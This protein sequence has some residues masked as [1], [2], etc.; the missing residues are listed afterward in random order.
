VNFA[1]AWLEEVREIADGLDHGAIDELAAQILAVR[2]RRG[3]I[4]VLGLGGSAANAQHCVNDLRVRAG[5]AAFS[6][7]DNVAELTAR[8][9]DYG[10]KNTLWGMLKASDLR[11]PD[12]VLILSGSGE[13]R[14]LYEAALY[15]TSCHATVLGIVGMPDSSI[16]KVCTH[17]VVIPCPNAEHRAGHAESF[18]AVIWHAVVDAIAEKR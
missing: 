14:A 11:K 10:W 6:P 1:K 5:L 17:Q 8:A 16:G 3:R 13:S 12:A 18:Q 2:I 4:F 15:A 7:A 9:N